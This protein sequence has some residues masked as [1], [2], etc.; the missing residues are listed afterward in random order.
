MDTKVYQVG[1]LGQFPSES[2]GLQINFYR[3]TKCV[4]DGVPMLPKS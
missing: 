2:E 4:N 3:N 1:E